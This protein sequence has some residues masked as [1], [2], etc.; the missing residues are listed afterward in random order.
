MIHMLHDN[1]D[2]N[3]DT[4]E[5]KLKGLRLPK[6][7]FYDFKVAKIFLNIVSLRSSWSHMIHMLYGNLYANSDT[8]ELKLHGLRLPKI[9]F[10]DFKVTI[11]F[12]VYW[13]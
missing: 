10:C 1:L 2:A 7:S 11:I 9:L 13:L 8:Q 4:Q 3:Y 6:T 5:L 12:I